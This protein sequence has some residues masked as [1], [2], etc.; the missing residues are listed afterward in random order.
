MCVC[1]DGESLLFPPFQGVGWGFFQF[2]FS[3]PAL[4]LPNVRIAAKIGEEPMR[5]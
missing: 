3:N 5:A 1:V 2:L 4:L